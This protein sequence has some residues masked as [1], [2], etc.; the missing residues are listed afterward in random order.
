MKTWKFAKNGWRYV[1]NRI[2]VVFRGGKYIFRSA[3]WFLEPR[4]D[5]RWIRGRIQNYWERKSFDNTKIQFLTFFLQQF[6]LGKYF[7]AGWNIKRC[8]VSDFSDITLDKNKWKIYLLIVK[9][10]LTNF[11]EREKERE[12]FSFFCDGKKFLHDEIT[13]FPKQRVYFNLHLLFSFVRK[14]IRPNLNTKYGTIIFYLTRDKTESSRF[15]IVI[16]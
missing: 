16:V 10:F 5:T 13:R 12:N 15:V 2:Y 9:Y 4:C 11:I 6:S 3:M 8:C 1:N 7:F 14:L